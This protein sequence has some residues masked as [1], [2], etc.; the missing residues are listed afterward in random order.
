LW[1]FSELPSEEVECL[2]DALVPP[3]DVKTI[4]SPAARRRAGGQRHRIAIARAERVIAAAEL[5]GAHEFILA[6]PDGYNT[7]VGER[8]ASLSRLLPITYRVQTVMWPNPASAAQA[9]D[10][11]E[12]P[13][14]DRRGVLSLHRRTGLDLPSVSKASQSV[15][16]SVRGRNVAATASGPTSIR[17][18]PRILHSRLSRAA[19]KRSER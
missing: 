19:A 3:R 8:G 2:Q 1:Q 10:I 17:K 11:Q 15:W 4:S 14:R 6:L 13:V 12:G 18:I 9:Q 16:A 5:A 7:I